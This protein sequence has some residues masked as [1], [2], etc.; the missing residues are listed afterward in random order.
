VTSSITVSAIA[1]IIANCAN[2][3]LSVAI[4]PP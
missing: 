3:C 2:S 1:L 4:Y